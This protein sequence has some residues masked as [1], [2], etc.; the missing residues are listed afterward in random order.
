MPLVRLQVLRQVAM[1]CLPLRTPLSSLQLR[2]LHPLQWRPLRQFL[3]SYQRLHS[4]HPEMPASTRT[5]GLALL[6]PRAVGLHGHCD[7]GTRHVRGALATQVCMHLPSRP[8]PAPARAY[9]EEELVL[10]CMSMYRR[11]DS[12]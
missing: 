3:Q 4:R 9:Q 12:C 6:L 2:Y 11:H 1:Q 7:E 10:Q 8:G 5:D